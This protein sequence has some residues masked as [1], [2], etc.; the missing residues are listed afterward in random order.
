MAPEPVESSPTAAPQTPMP[1]W[2]V[3]AIGLFWLGLVALWLLQQLFES[4]SGFLVTIL[5]SFF[6]SFALEP[7]V[8]WLERRGVRRGLGTFLMFSAAL[9]GIAAFGWIVGTVLAEQTTQFVN[10]APAL[11]DDLE[12]WLQDNV[13]ESVDLDRVRDRFLSDDGLGEQ[14]TGL[15]DNVVGLGATVVGL[16]FDIFTIALFTFYLTADGPRLRRTICARLKPERQ[17]R[18]LGVWDLAIQKTGGYILS[19]TVLALISSI[20]T[21]IAFSII[22]VPFPLALAA[23]VGVVSQFVPVVGVYIAGSLPLILT[24][25]E[26]P[27]KALW[28]LLFMIGYQQIE[29]YL[30]APR[31]DSKTLKIHPAVSFGSVLA[32]ASILGPVGALLALPAAATAQGIISASGERYAI[33]EGP[34]TRLGPAAEPKPASVVAATLPRHDLDNDGVVDDE[35]A[36]RTE[37]SATTELVEDDS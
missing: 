2:V 23:W 14:L 11:I 10:D 35:L 16:V 34:L 32:G 15:A 19:R 21:W 20:V 6:F 12:I 3:R 30:L 17:R 28:A 22:G 13:D 7:A 8:N 31:I 36:I 33:E 4:L 26:S 18:V 9:I 37:R 5:I 1:R 24:L 25:L 29:N 27:T